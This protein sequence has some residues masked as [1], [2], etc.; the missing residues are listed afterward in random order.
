MT[1]EILVTVD[2]RCI[3]VVL[4]HQLFYT[5]VYTGRGYHSV[6]HTSKLAYLY[7]SAFTWEWLWIHNPAV[8]FIHIHIH[9]TTLQPPQQRGSRA[10]GCSETEMT[11]PW[12]GTRSSGVREIQGF[13]R[14]GG[15]GTGAD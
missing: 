1:K 4:C 14:A 5:I 12:S 10:E 9:A 3:L 7:R 2:L 15:S 8:D 11:D 6:V 13:A